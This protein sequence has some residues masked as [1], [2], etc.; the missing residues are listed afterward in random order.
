MLKLDD[1]YNDVSIITLKII[2]LLL[3]KFIN[4]NYLSL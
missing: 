1:S 4:N 2:K 3:A